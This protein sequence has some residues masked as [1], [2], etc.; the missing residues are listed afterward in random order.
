MRTV[1]RINFTEKNDNN[2]K[3]FILPVGEGKFLRSFSR[4][5]WGSNLGRL[6][7]SCYKKMDVK[8]I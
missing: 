6:T 8:Q 5:T 1:P 7:R 3:E 2:L 4:K